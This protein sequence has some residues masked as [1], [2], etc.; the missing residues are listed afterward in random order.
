MRG[1]HRRRPRGPR[2]H[3]PPLRGP[4]EDARQARRAAVLA[5]RALVA[6]AR[7]G[8]PRRGWRRLRAPPAAAASPPGTSRGRARRSQIH[9]RVLHERRRGHRCERARR[10]RL[11]DA[12]GRAG[13]EG[14]LSPAVAAGARS[15]GRRRRQARVGRRARARGGTKHSPPETPNASALAPAGTRASRTR[16]RVG[17]GPGGRHGGQEAPPGRARRPRKKPRR[18]RRRRA[19]R[20]DAA[21]KFPQHPA[22]R[23][24]R[25]PRWR[26]ARAAR[27]PRASPP[28][29]PTRTCG[30]GARARSPAPARSRRERARLRAD[31]A[32]RAAAAPRAARRGA[33]RPRSRRL[34]VQH[35]AR[36]ARGG[37]G[38]VRGDAPADAHGAR[39]RAP[40]GTRR[41]S[42]RGR[43]P[44]DVL[45]ASAR[46]VTAR[47]CGPGA[48]RPGAA[49]G[50]EAP[51]GDASR[52]V[53]RG[54]GDG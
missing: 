50:R 28:T 39:A 19:P 26:C 32:A 12:R 6:G 21:A 31:A 40:P 35:G 53:P 33:P 46:V 30:V 25:S 34:R 15:G 42:R 43:R 29:Q 23:A 38:R 7:S 13:A 14:L 48:D 4:V 36:R 3:R 18:R 52:R 45:V 49:R 20:K 22:S 41:R 1:V 54:G 9:L 27:S 2:A 8:I 24:P 11:G 16:A 51:R 17:D 5:A 37:R 47:S 10:L 44:L